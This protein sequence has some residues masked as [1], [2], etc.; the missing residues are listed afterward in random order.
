MILLKQL[1]DCPDK[2]QFTAMKEVY[3]LLRQLGNLTYKGNS[4]TDDF[5]LALSNLEIKRQLQLLLRESVVLQ[6]RFSVIPNNPN[7]L[8][9]KTILFFDICTPLHRTPT[10]TYC[11]L[12]KFSIKF[13]SRIQAII[14]IHLDIM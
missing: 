11:I 9:L 2:Q 1:I 10:K 5:N 6:N 12:N 8:I 14:E 3:S 4:Y 7:E 13:Y